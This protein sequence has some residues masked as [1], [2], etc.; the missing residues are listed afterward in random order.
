MLEAT[1]DP[2][3]AIDLCWIP[4][5]V[6]ASELSDLA[7]AWTP[8][9]SSRSLDLSDLSWQSIGSGSSQ[10]D[11]EDGIGVRVTS[12]GENQRYAFRMR[13]NHD[14][15]WLISNDA[16]ALLVDSSKPLRTEVTAGASGL[17]GD[18]LV[19]GLICRDYDDPATTED[20]AG[21]FFLS[22]GFTTTSAEYLRY[23]PVNDFDPASD[24]TLVNAT[25][26]L[27]DRPY[28]T[29]LGYRVRITPSVWGEPV[30]VSLAADVVTHGETS[31]GNQASGEFRRETSDAVDCDT[32]PP[33]SRRAGRRSWPRESKQDGD[34]NGEWTAGEPI[35]V[36]LQFDERISVDTTDGVP[37]VKLTLGETETEA[38]VPFSHVAHED[39]LVFEHPVTADESPIGNITLLADSLSLNGGQIDSF[40][41]PAVDLAHAGAAVVGGQIVQPDLTAGWS[42]IPGAH[43]GS[44]TGF[45]IHLQFSEDV[46]L[47]EVIGE[48]YLLEHAFTVTGGSIEAIRPARDR[49]GEYL[50]NEWAMRVLPASEEP[51]TISPVVEL[52]CDQPGAIC[53]IDDRTLTEAPSVTVHR[54]EQGLSVADAEVGEGPGAVLVFE[55]TLARAADEP[56]TVDYETAD[57][58]ATAGEDYEAVS[59]TL[60]IEAGQTAAS[61]RVSIID[62]SHDEGEE[63]L[64]LV[65]TNASN[66]QIHDGEALGI[67]VNS[68]PIP[69]A[70]LARFGRAA[71]DHVAQAVARRLERGPSEEHM[72]VGGVRLDRLF[73]SFA[74]PDGGR[75]ASASTPVGL[76]SLGSGAMQP[77]LAWSATGSGYRNAQPAG[78]LDTETFS[79][80]PAGGFGALGLAGDMTA[81]YGGTTR[82][83]DTLPSLRDVLMGSSF[84]YTHGESDDASSSPLTAWGETASTRFKG[85]E[86]ALSLDGEVTTAML[87]LD[88]RYG[89][90]LVGSTLSYSEG[91]GG[92]RGSGALGGS[93]DSTLTSLNPYAHFE[94][95]ETTSLWGVFGYGSGS[96]RVTPQGAASA[97][98]TDLS[99]RMA[100]FGG[101]GLLSVRTGDAGRFELALRSDAL[102]TRT[103]SDAVQGLAGAQGATSRVRLILEGSGSIPLSTGGVLKPSLEAGLRYDGG[104]AETG[105]GIELGGGLGYTAGSLSVEVNARALM[106]H[107]DTDYEEWGFSGSLAYTPGKD[108]RGLSMKLGSAWGSTQSGVQSL[109]TRQDASGLAGTSPFEAAQ[110]FQAELGYGIAGR[111]K[112]A[113]WVP[114]IAAQA[115][116]GDSQSLR[117][118]VKLT[119]GPNVEAGLELGRLENRRLENGRGG[120]PEHAVHLRGALRW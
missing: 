20:E 7:M 45:D 13:A 59:G 92:Y 46:D 28:D 10:V 84:F 77:P 56:V 3:P 67:I 85:S 106:A 18:T 118:G 11:C 70:W 81:P 4:E 104:D 78:G 37:S 120:A 109:W 110:R 52:A 43:E 94:L 76:N 86:G 14:G 100:A 99:N 65:L 115:A 88:K 96:L 23:E 51:V 21:S 71:S 5:G 24:L 112:A 80:G 25:A 47:V 16:E 108:G 2:A 111:R 34:R 102:V 119:S 40:S 42:T 114:F 22:I 74:D 113:L 41:G 69:S 35:R 117:M 36:T 12:I 82:G 30:A 72:T 107:E 97:I 9:Q 39:T 49:R 62:D 33:R 50:A 19:P 93:M 55:V 58:T 68:D 87:G 60:S 27:L 54:T 103:D 31:V 61:V 48:R 32:A 116:D 15:V 44:E 90:W 57:G 101:R 26:E 1:A 63:T 95:N 89:R 83:S 91:E 6:A 98:E 53:T 75:V 29:Q 17:S 66:A 64:T 105:A 8:V 38:M 73:T 79:S